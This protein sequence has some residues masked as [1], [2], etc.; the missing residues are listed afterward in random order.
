MSS[1]TDLP[2][3]PESET[4]YC[5]PG[6][7]RP[8]GRAVHLARLAAGHR[9]CSQCVHRADIQT[10]PKHIAQRT[11]SR[12][13]RT[14][15]SFFSANGIRGIY[16]NQL[17]RRHVSEITER[18]LQIADEDR[19]FNSELPYRG[20]L[21]V[22]TGYDSRTMSADLAVGMVYVLQ[23][24]GC[25]IADVGRVSRPAFDSARDQL[26]PHLG[27]YLTGGSEP[28][29]WSGLDLIDETGLPWS[30]PGKLD[31]LREKLASPSSRLSR[32]QGRYEAVNLQSDYES[33]LESL[34]HGI[35]P[36]RL[37][38]A[39]PDPLVRA[40]LKRAFDNTSCSVQF[41][42]GNVSAFNGIDRLQKT[43]VDVLCDQR[44]DAGFLI[45]HDGRE[46]RIFDEGGYELTLPE[47]ISLLQ[48]GLPE[49]DHR[50]C[51]LNFDSVSE[52]ELAH[53]TRLSGTEADL[54]RH[55][56]EHEIPLA[57]DSSHRFWFFGERPACDAIQTM[58]RML[59]ILSQ[60]DRPVSSYRRQKKSIARTL[61]R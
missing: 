45:G 34:L 48:R 30:S 55:Q 59:T 18:V 39:A 60:S 31:L 27:I 23:R 9:A 7:T 33:S 53:A 58:A 11:A 25:R 13:S 17:T 32:S 56:Q 26:H 43:L 51:M 47:T 61:V 54:L 38:I 41:L 57:V 46:C 29:S 22:V 42:A 12:L 16:I 10:L 14:T 6:E 5:C 2:I 35:R 37:V 3:I 15:T 1:L 19:A 21:R 52:G 44:V 28:H 24:W 40:S 36:L 4:G 50:V 49:T 8:I 20:P